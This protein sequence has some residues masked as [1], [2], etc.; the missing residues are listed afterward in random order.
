MQNHGIGRPCR[1]GLVLSSVVRVTDTFAGVGERLRGKPHRGQR[2]MKIAAQE[3][4]RCS[5]VS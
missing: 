2:I 4:I 3:G 1:S 5:N